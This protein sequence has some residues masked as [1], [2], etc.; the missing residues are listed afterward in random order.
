QCSEDR[1]GPQEERHRRAGQLS[2]DDN[3]PDQRDVARGE[4]TPRSLRRHGTPRE[5]PPAQL[6]H[7]SLA[8]DA[9]YPKEGALTPRGGQA[10]LRRDRRRE[11][12]AESGGGGL[13]RRTTGALQEDESVGDAGGAAT[14]RTESEAERI[15]PT[16]ENTPVDDL[17]RGDG[18]HG[19][20][21]PQRLLQR[22][23]SGEAVF[24]RGRRRAGD[25]LV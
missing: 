17:R 11:Q 24:R 8:A 14:G 16:A 7:Q 21:F 9:R 5:L 15:R 20:G 18:G 12:L 19:T 6:F 25:D 13:A 10:I 23:G 4:R 2:H 22:G 1:C 3:G